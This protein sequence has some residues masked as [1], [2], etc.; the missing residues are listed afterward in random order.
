M[1]AVLTSCSYLM[2]N[3]GSSDNNPI[4][5]GCI[6]VL[7]LVI[8]VLMRRH[9]CDHVM[10]NE[11]T[12]PCVIVICATTM[13]ISQLQMPALYLRQLHCRCGQCWATSA[14]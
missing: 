3:G 6:V 2:K 7:G 4:A 1:I 14:P 9:H 13:V 12:R 11:A 10:T 8:V 5:L